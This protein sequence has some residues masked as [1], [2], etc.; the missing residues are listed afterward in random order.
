MA[1][2][3]SP[4]RPPGGMKPG[5]EVLRSI[6]L[7]TSRIS[8]AEQ[9]WLRGFDGQIILLGRGQIADNGPGARL[10]TQTRIRF[11]LPV[12]FR[13][14]F[15]QP[16]HVIALPGRGR[17]EGPVQPIQL[18]IDGIGADGFSLVLLPGLGSL[19]CSFD[20]HWV[21]IGAARGN[22][23][24]LIGTDAPQV[25][26]PGPGARLALRNAPPLL[27]RHQLRLSDLAAQ[28]L[29]L[30]LLPRAALQRG[31]AARLGRGRSPQADAYQGPL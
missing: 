21:A 25:D 1:G 4:F 19:R 20:F 18:E 22:D 10:G 24:E 27:S 16:P 28:A 7:A 9:H 29:R 14:A 17:G 5:G 23:L 11:L 6:W 13:L 26:G 8:N 3:R 31:A 12:R 30:D 15:E 2:I